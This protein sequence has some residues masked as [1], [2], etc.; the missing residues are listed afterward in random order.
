MRFIVAIISLA[1]L[2]GPAVAEVFQWEGNGHYYEYLGEPG[3]DTPEFENLTWNEAREVAESRVYNGMAGHLATV[4]SEGE[5]GFMSG[6]CCIPIVYP[7]TAPMLG[8]W[9]A[10]E[11]DPAPGGELGWRWITGEP[12]DEST[13][14]PYWS[15]N[16]LEN[17]VGSVLAAGCGVAMST[18]MCTYVAI[19]L[20]DVPSGNGF[21]VEYDG[22]PIIDAP[23][24]GAVQAEIRTWDYIKS[25]FK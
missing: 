25:Q 9:N 17:Q 22:L 7:S 4:T 10:A 2:S 23:P 21:F 11:W 18:I 15:Y 8:G 16:P 13:V 1:F 19:D 3:G 5:W 6:M 24:E 20:P 12:F 14:G